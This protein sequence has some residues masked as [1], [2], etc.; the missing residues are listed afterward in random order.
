MTDNVGFF[1]ALAAGQQVEHLENVPRS[2]LPPDS[3]AL[4]ERF[5]Q[6]PAPHLVASLT[7]VSEADIARLAARVRASGG[8]Q[9][10]SL[11]LFERV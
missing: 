11:A 3:P 6:I 10:P 1:R 8:Y 2:L 7:A 5:G 4:R 9:G